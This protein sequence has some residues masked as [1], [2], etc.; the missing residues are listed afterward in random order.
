MFGLHCTCLGRCLIAEGCVAYQLM[1]PSQDCG[2]YNK[3]RSN[4]IIEN[5]DKSKWRLFR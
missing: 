5:E 1:F 2:T 3:N 4:A